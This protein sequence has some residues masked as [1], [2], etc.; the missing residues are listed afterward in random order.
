MILS[1]SIALHAAPIFSIRSAALHTAP[2][3]SHSV[4]RRFTPLQYSPTLHRCASLQSNSFLPALFFFDSAPLCSCP[5]STLYF[6]TPLFHASRHYNIFP[7]QS[8]TLRAALIF[9]KPLRGVKYPSGRFVA[10]KSLRVYCTPY[11]PSISPLFSA[12]S[13]QFVSTP[14][15]LVVK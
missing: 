13:L 1:S 15:F 14:Y 9:L 5:S 12:S 10:E 7:P 4:R 6:S 2:E 3:F 11:T 8:A